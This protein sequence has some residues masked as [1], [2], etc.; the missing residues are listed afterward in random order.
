MNDFISVCVNKGGYKIWV[1]VKMDFYLVSIMDS[2]LGI[3][4]GVMCFYGLEMDLILIYGE[5][6]KD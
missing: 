5:F 1:F 6:E 3:S 4:I 2:L